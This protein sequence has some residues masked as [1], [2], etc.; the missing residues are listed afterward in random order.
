MVLANKMVK[1]GLP[2]SEKVRGS[3]RGEVSGR[4]SRKRAR[5]C[6]APLAVLVHEAPTAETHAFY[7]SCL[8]QQ[9]VI[10]EKERVQCCN[11]DFLL[12]SQIT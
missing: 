3:F 7:S 10:M 1:I 8:L 4:E 9:I 6:A 2:N 11:W 12:P 5:G